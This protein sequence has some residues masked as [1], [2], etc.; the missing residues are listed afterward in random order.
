MNRF[1]LIKT[2]RILFIILLIL[3]YVFL[4]YGYM[5]IF[6]RKKD[7]SIL[8]FWLFSFLVNVVY[9]IINILKNK[10]SF[11]FLILYTIILNFFVLIFIRIFFIPDLL[12]YLSMRGF[13]T[14]LYLYLA[15]A[16]HVI[17]TGNWIIPLIFYFG[18]AQVTDTMI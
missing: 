15:I 10:K 1:Y 18:R 17:F 9:I 14:V 2:I 7:M 16:S 8:F 5:E 12:H 11:R 13:L 4:A 6:F 3:G